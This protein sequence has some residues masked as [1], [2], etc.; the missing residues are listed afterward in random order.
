MVD[1]PSGNFWDYYDFIWFYRDENGIILGYGW[2]Y[3]ETERTGKIHHFRRKNPLF[4]AVFKSYME[5]YGKIKY[6]MYKDSFCHS[7]EPSKNI[8]QLPHESLKE[9]TRRQPAF[10]GEHFDHFWFDKGAP[11]VGY[12]R[13]CIRICVPDRSKYFIL[14]VEA[15]P[16]VLSYLIAIP[17]LFRSLRTVCT[18]NIM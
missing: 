11:P 2:I 14:W 1:I 17:D 7:L 10:K 15:W 8:Q 16:Q 13:Y 3:L 12:C 4:L 6:K 5:R 9:Q 18:C